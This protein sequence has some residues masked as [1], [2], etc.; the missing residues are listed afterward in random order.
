[1]YA[2]KNI[3]NTL[4]LREINYLYL[5]ATITHVHLFLSYSVN[6][7]VSLNKI[8]SLNLTLPY[9]AYTCHHIF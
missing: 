8:S 9:K 1:M 7:Y 5:I 3:L 2:L 6:I 4:K